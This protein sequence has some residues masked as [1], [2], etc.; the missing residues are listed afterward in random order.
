MPGV[1][2]HTPVGFAD[3]SQTE[4][5][6]PAYQLS[7]QEGNLFLDVFQ[8]P[9]IAVAE[10]FVTR[11][12]PVGPFALTIGVAVVDE[13]ALEEGFDDP[14]EGVMDD[15]VPKRHRGHRAAFGFANL[16]GLV[17]ARTVAPAYEFPLQAQNLRLQIGQKR[18]Y[19]RFGSFSLR[20]LPGR[21][22]QD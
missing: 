9:P 17:P 21:L 19:A 11:N 22:H 2:I 16:D 3:R 14:T 12:R 8:H 15:T 4:I 1:G 6:A 10:P 18:C 5:V 20:R 7:V 13:T